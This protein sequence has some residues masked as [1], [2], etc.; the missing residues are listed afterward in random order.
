MVTV[1]TGLSTYTWDPLS[2]KHA[3]CYDVILNSPKLP[4]KFPCEQVGRNLLFIEEKLLCMIICFK[5]LLLNNLFCVDN[6][7][8][9]FHSLMIWLGLK[10]LIN[11]SNFHLRWLE[12]VSWHARPGS[13]IARARASTPGSRRCKWQSCTLQNFAKFIFQSKISRKADGENL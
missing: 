9:S 13:L 6:Y 3:T 8:E 7:K 1:N 2:P 12:T 5:F 11:K 4:L 10:E